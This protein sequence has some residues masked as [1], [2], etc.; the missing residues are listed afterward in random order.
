MVVYRS[1]PIPVG[2][3]KIPLILNFRSLRYVTHM[4]IKEFV[5]FLNSYKFIAKETEPL[6][7]DEDINL[8]IQESGKNK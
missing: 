7:S 4:K 8:L 2:E 3:L 1:S 6:S 5:S